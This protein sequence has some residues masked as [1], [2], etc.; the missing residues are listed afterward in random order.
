MTNPSHLERLVHRPR[1]HGRLPFCVRSC[2]IHS[3]K[4]GLRDQHRQRPFWQLIWCE[5]GVGTV[6]LNG[7]EHSL[8]AQ[9]YVW[10]RPSDPHDLRSQGDWRCHWLTIDG[11]ASDQ[12][13]EHCCPFQPQ[14]Q[15]AGP[16]PVHLFNEIAAQIS[17]PTPDA[18]KRAAGLAFELLQ[19]AATGSVRPSTALADQTHQLIEQHFADPGCDVTRLAQLLKMHRSHFTRQFCRDE[20]VSPSDALQARRVREAIHLLTSTGDPIAR[21]ASQTGYNDPGYFARVMKKITGRCPRDI[22]QG[23]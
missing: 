16:C 20:G 14:P 8:Q 1:L 15:F 17:D 22:R 2:G 4:N 7:Q 10:H 23:K 21:V 18:E 6:N 12:I 9:H 5:S 11:P 19:H 13:I 3:T